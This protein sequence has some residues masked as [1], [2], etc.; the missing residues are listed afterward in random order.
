MALVA[1]ILLI[2]TSSS[3]GYSIEYFD[4]HNIQK[5]RTYRLD[6]SCTAKPYNLSNTEKTTYTIVQKR[7][8]TEMLGFSC[9]IIK[10]TL[11]E[12]C[13][14]FSHAKLAKPP[15]VEV[16]ELLPAAS[17]MALINTQ[18]YATSDG[19][20]VKLNL[21]EENVIHTSDFGAIIIKDNSVTCRGQQVRVGNEIVDDIFQI[22][23]LKITLVKEKFLIIQKEGQKVV[24]V[25]AKHLQLPMTCTLESGGCTTHDTTY[26][27]TRPSTSCDFEEV[28]TVEMV[29]QNDF[30]VD[31]MHKVLL[32]K[33]TAMPAPA[34]C[35]N[36]L[37]YATEYPDLYLTTPEQDFPKIKGDVNVVLFTM[38]RDDFIVWEVERKLHDQKNQLRQEICQK[39]VDEREDEILQVD[40]HPPTFLRRNGDVLEHFT[41]KPMTEA[42]A[43]DKKTCYEDIPLK[44]GFVKV[45]SRIYS[46]HSRPKPCNPHFPLKIITK[47]GV[48]I[49]INPGLKPIP[50]PE[51]LPTEVDMNFD[52]EDMSK[53]G[54]YT[55][56]ELENWR[57]H[58]ELGDIHKAITRSISMGVCSQKGSCEEQEATPPL[59]L[60]RLVTQSIEGMGIFA[61]IKSF[62]VRNGAYLSA[63]VLF[64]ETIKLAVT[65]SIS[66]NHV[67]TDG[68][69][70][71]KAL[72]YTLCCGQMLQSQ[73][74]KRRARRDQ[75][76]K[77]EEA[78]P[79]QPP[80]NWN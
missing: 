24:E 62:I 43:T 26:V 11:T 40:D 15:I 79:L 22:T 75:E 39:A 59:D 9:K 45:R 21:N 38:A 69:E 63:L 20:Q 71:A 57:K 77:R 35:P 4:C 76:R 7:D 41:C 8:T 14:A 49:E 10:T 13:G 52:H 25:I 5:L 65:I 61:K 34:G 30:L 12:F 67:I 78:V 6:Q 44:T 55:E 1:L 46:D 29:E 53:G 32:K 60:Q 72:I 51:T 19:R 68:L 33:R 66:I 27:W 54:L 16:A 3:Q 70:G 37:L 50:E 64:L 56:L 74:I 2:S 47:E 48:W 28:R 31:Y 73:K 80:H 23:Q 17:C 18:R 58:I 42:I 36:T